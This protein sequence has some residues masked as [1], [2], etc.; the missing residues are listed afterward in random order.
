MACAATPGIARSSRGPGLATSSGGRT[1]PE[2]A[3]N[4]VGALLSAAVTVVR[5]F[6]RRERDR[7]DGGAERLGHPERQGEAS[8]APRA[9]Y[10]VVDVT[11]C[12]GS[13]SCLKACPEGEVLTFRDGVPVLAH[14]EKCVGH[15]VCA[16]ECPTDAIRLVLGT[17]ER[18]VKLPELRGCY[19]TSRSGIHVVGELAGAP[20]LEQAVRQGLAVGA[21]L[22][23]RLRTS[24][25]GAEVVIAGAGPAGLAVAFALAEAGVAYR[26][27]ERS[28]VLSTIRAYP[29]G[30]IVTTRALALPGAG[31]I[32]RGRIS[33][34]RLLTRCLR[35]IED[36]DIRVEEGVEVHAIDGRDGAYT[37]RTSTGAIRAHKVVLAIGRAGSPR[38]LG[39]P[40]E[41]LAKVIIGLGNPAEH[42]GRRVLVVG[43]GDAAVEGAIALA[44]SGAAEVILCHR[45]ETFSR[46]RDENRRALGSAIADGRVRVI[47]GGRITRIDPANVELATPEGTRSLAN[48]VVVL[49]LGRALPVRFL[50]ASG[51]AL[52]AYSGDPAE[53]GTARRSGTARAVLRSA[54]VLVSTAAPA[55]LLFWLQEGWDY[56]RLPPPLRGH[57]PLHAALRPSS[58][59]GASLGAVS[60][61]LMLVAFAYVARQ[62]ARWLTGVGDVRAWFDVHVATG[63]LSLLTVAVHAAFT[64]H[65]ALGVATFAALVALFVSGAIGRFAPRGLRPGALPL[66]TG[67]AGGTEAGRTGGIVLVEDPGGLQPR[68]TWRTIHQVAAAFVAVAVGAHVVVAV[69]FGYV[70]G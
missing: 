17:R 52:K 59:L 21:H 66:L 49:A 57:S 40:G 47:L 35:A 67:A 13:G 36:G 30:K 14:P 39:V 61:V 26:I 1:T 60:M 23:A 5:G 7:P 58:H 63:A 16:D 19:E 31:L 28:E 64:T 37:V 54:L 33:R 2:A 53:H 15:G 55:M 41:D 25:A 34:E 48:D 18:V 56:Y 32:A 45:G 70:L 6:A 50:E 8:F 44:R 69:L 51:I 9:L 12:T 42:A 10:P 20:L 43:G 27:L 4:V 65:H 22:A 24:P 38:R 62:R 11:R 68:R 3:V 29:A 46:C